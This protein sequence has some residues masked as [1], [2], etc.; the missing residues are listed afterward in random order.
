MKKATVK[1]A[2]A[3]KKPAKT[4]TVKKGMKFGKMC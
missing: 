3:V 2:K 4:A 1:A